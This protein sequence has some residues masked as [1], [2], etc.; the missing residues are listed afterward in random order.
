MTKYI[1]YVIIGMLVA[2]LFFTRECQRPDPC[3]EQPDP[4][5]RIDT[6]IKEIVVEKT[7]EKPVPI[8]IH[9]SIPANLPIDTMQV[10]EDYYKYRVYQLKLKDDTAAD[11]SLRAEVW[12]NELTRVKL[13]G[14]IHQKTVIRTETRT[15]YVDQKRRKVFFGAQISTEFSRPGSAF[16]IQPGLAAAMMYQSKKDHA[17]SVGYDPFNR[18]AYGTFWYK[19]SFK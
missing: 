4:V 18:V 15:E 2:T 7:V 13:Y 10:V 17:Y 8:Y 16:S 3:P 11:L 19:I 5:V 14:E 6:I 9:D 1:P 12:K